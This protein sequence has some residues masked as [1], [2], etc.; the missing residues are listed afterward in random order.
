[1]ICEELETPVVVVIS[2]VAL[3]FLILSISAGTNWLMKSE[4]RNSLIEMIFGS[5]FASSLN[6]KMKIH[7]LGYGCPVIE[8][9]DPLAYE[10]IQMRCLYAQ[11]PTIHV[12]E[13]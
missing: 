11:K 5:P 1:M 13:P 6:L 3:T 12:H 8:V 2:Q 10:E 7:S 4:S 9:P